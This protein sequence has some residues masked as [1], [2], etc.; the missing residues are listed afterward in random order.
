MRPGSRAVK[1]SKGTAQG[2]YF[3]GSCLKRQGDPR[4]KQYLWQAI[5]EQPWRLAAWWK[6]IG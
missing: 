4:A 6:L 2:N 5:R 3:I 1:K